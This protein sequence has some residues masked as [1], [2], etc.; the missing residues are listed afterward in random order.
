MKLVRNIA[1]LLIAGMLSV[2]LFT[3]PGVSAW[4]Q[5]H[6]RPLG[7]PFL[8]KLAHFC[9]FFALTFLVFRLSPPFWRYHSLL[10]FMAVIALLAELI[11]VLVPVREGS[12]LDFAANLFGCWCCY[13]LLAK[14][15]RL[16]PHANAPFTKRTPNDT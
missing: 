1:L 15:A 4:E 5:T 6:L 16:M 7:I 13:R 11:Q 8:D 9:I 12:L 2:W 14:R 3:S 10:K